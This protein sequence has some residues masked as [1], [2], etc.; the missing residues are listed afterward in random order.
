MLIGRY[1]NDFSIGG[2][3]LMFQNGLITFSKII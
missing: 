3:N 1:V 2:E